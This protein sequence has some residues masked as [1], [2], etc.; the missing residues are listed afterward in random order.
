MQGTGEHRENLRTFITVDGVEPTNTTA[1]R[2]LRHEGCTAAARRGV[3]GYGGYSIRA[4]ATREFVAFEKW[5]ALIRQSI[6]V[7]SFDH[8][9]TW[10]GGMIGIEDRE[11]AAK[12]AGEPLHERGV[13]HA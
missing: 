13:V 2:T 9:D 5:A 3:N 7:A 6:T 12:A 1:E 8:E 11:G 4:N 10:G